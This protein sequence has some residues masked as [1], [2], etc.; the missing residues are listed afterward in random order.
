MY[1]NSRLYDIKHSMNI[2]Q[3]GSPNYSTGRGGKP[4]SLI[5]VHHMAGTLAATDSVFQNTQRNTSAHYGVGRNGEVHQY[6]ADGDTAFHAGN[7]DINQR[8]VGIEHEDLASDS[9]TDLEYQT[10]AALIRSLCLRYNLPINATTI[11]PHRDF[12][13]TACPGS[14]DIN[15]LI[16]L[17]K[18]NNMGS[19]AIVDETI[20]RLCYNGILFRDPVGDEWKVHNNGQTVE[21]CM[22]SFIASPEHA[23]L[24]KKAADAPD[25]SSKKLASLRTALQDILK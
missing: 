8:S 11:R 14:L 13:A 4:I 3:V 6:V 18:G 25:S 5:V 19:Q 21:S 23:A 17:A 24:V 9:Y 10:S 1:P 16:N 12:I 22:R 2:Q 15:R 7:Y 20:V